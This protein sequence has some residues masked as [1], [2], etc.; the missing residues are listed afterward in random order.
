[1][2]VQPPVPGEG[3]TLHRIMAR[4]LPLQWGREIRTEKEHAA[5]RLSLLKS[6]SWLSSLS[7]EIPGWIPAWDVRRHYQV[8]ANQHNHIN[9][10][11][12]HGRIKDDFLS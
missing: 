12:P 9:K 5:Q 3:P 7:S 6:V 10:L 11:S 2:P 1:M 8:W 4:V